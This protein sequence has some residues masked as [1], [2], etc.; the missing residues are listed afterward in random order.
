MTLDPD[1]CYRAICARD[2][3]YDGRFFICVHTTGIFCRPICPARTPLRKN[4]QF[5]ETAE[6]A[7]QLGFRACKRCRPEVKAGSAAWDLTAASIKRALRMID[8]GAL[9]EQSID[10]F[11]ERL[12]IGA[13]HL[14]RLVK[15]ALG[16]APNRLALARRAGF[17]RGLIEGSNL[18]MTEVAAASGF[19][20]LR[21][22]NDVVQKEFGASPT[23][24]RLNAG[25]SAGNGGMNLT[26]KA[27][28]AVDWPALFAFYAARTIPGVETAQD[29]RYVRALRTGGNLALIS[30]EAS[31]ANAVQ[32]SVTGAQ[33]GEL[34][35]V[36]GRIRRALDLDTDVAAVT[37]ALSADRVL[38][39][40]LVRTSALR[41]PG[42]W[43]PFE[44]SVRAM[45]G[46]QISVKAA[47][48]LAGRIVAAFGERLPLALKGQGPT[49]AF[50][51]A[52]DLAKAEV[53]DVM[54]LGLTTARAKALI[55]LAQAVAKDPTIFSPVSSLAALVEKLCALDGV[56]PWT[57]HYV[58]LRAFGESDAFP[59]PDLG[60]RKAY[61]ALTGALPTAQELERASAKWSPW[62]GYAAQALWTHLSHLET[63]EPRDGMAA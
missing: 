39:T 36:T 45:L 52:K 3:R 53:P 62:R 40:A 2:P 28:G 51:A 16:V 54:A 18:A 42:S 26:L 38:K 41:L 20:S 33:V 10:D 49:H 9:D 15:S 48:T 24:L 32:V 31:G 8:A 44:L 43:D 58:A 47:R 5:V 27:K 30:I 12:G 7:L 25:V 1:E 6:A 46:Q 23:Q 22:F 11:S 21:R 50:P 13:R 61:G 19:G 55:G 37:K 59:A 17:A 4:V 63:K 34:Y 14:R 60:L 56:G 57:A 29:G 35:A